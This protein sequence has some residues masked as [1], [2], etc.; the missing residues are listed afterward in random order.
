[1]DEAVNI[2]EEALEITRQMIEETNQGHGR[3]AVALSNSSVFLFETGISKKSKQQLERALELARKTCEDKPDAVFINEVLPIVLNNLSLTEFKTNKLSEGLR[4]LEE[5]YDLQSR[6]VEIA[7][8]IF[9][10]NYTT[11]LNNLGVMRFKN[12]DVEIA[13][14]LIQEAL[15][16]RTKLA[17]R[18]QDQYG[19]ALSASYFNL[20]L[21]YSN[22]DREKESEMNKKKA[23]ESLNVI[24]S[25]GS[26]FEYQVKEM[27]KTIE[28]DEWILQGIEVIDPPFW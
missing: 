6:L 14:E 9:S 23:L 1:M 18:S 8:S 27:R 7:P 20:S 16:K 17:E 3:L 12:G 26:L 15:D 21:L 2:H 4:H 22:T 24:D 13:E 10:K 5:A 28:D 11:I 25:K 19:L